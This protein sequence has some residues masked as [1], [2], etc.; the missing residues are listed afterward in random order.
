MNIGDSVLYDC[1]KEGSH[2][3]IIMQIGN[4][5]GARNVHIVWSVGSPT[6]EYVADAARWLQDYLDT[7][8]KP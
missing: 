7:L 6:W 2:T 1:G 5:N 3:G 4:P 8:G